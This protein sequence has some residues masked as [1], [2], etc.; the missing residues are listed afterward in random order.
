VHL[1]HV[2]DHDRPG[3]FNAADEE[4]CYS[5]L[6]RRTGVFLSTETVSGPC[7]LTADVDPVAIADFEVTK[8][9]AKHRTFVVPHAIA[10]TLHFAPCADR[11]S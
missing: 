9:G 2:R 4:E 7:A 1:F 11:A 5:D 10:A 3:A 8:D 6:G